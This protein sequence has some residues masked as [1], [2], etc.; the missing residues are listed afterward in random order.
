MSQARILV[1]DD[2]PRLLRVLQLRL[3]SEGYAIT[4]VT[5]AEDALSVLDDVRPQFVLTD[6]KMTQ[7]GMDGT[8][9]VVRIQE[10]QPGLPVA[11][12]TAHAD[13]KEAIRATHAGAVDFL[14]KPVRR[15]ELGEPRQA[16]G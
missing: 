11:V 8:D 12:L 15:R 16:D 2:D 6:L 13:I 5:S 1:V 14:T 9:L 4:A 3:E 7:G 10:R